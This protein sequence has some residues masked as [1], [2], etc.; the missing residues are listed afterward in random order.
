MEK[1]N[2]ETSKMSEYLNVN[3]ELRN[4]VKLFVGERSKTQ[5]DSG[6][7]MFDLNLHE[8]HQVREK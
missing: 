7:K 8:P 1:A 4:Q 3:Y 6:C 5:F 2:E